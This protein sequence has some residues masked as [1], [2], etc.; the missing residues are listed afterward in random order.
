M[1]WLFQC[2][3]DPDPPSF[4]TDDSGSDE[5]RLKKPIL[6]STDDTYEDRISRDSLAD[7]SDGDGEFSED[8]SFI[9]E[10]AGARYRDS[11]SEPS[12]ASGPSTATA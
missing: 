1:F 11:I 10:Y 12:G 5:K 4:V 6:G 9:G 8:G 7:Y 2:D 3:T